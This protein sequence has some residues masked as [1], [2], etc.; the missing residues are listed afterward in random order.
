MSLYKQLADYQAE[1]LRK[2]KVN[3]NSKN[4]QYKGFTSE[5]IDSF[6]NTMYE[7][8]ELAMKKFMQRNSD[9]DGDILVDSMLAIRQMEQIKRDLM[10][11]RLG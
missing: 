11:E 3:Q 4:L 2:K 10:I 9:S 7:T 1:D 6:L 8:H 5:D